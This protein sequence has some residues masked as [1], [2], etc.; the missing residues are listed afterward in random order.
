MSRWQEAINIAGMHRLYSTGGLA[1][2]QL[3]KAIIRKLQNLEAFTTSDPGLM[4]VID[5]FNAIDEFARL[6]IIIRL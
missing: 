1:L 3:A 5:G 4:D 6:R 2:P